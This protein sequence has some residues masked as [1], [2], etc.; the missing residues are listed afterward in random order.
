MASSAPSAACCSV[1][2]S[3][4]R[5]RRSPWVPTATRSFRFT[6]TYG[7]IALSAVIATF[8]ATFAALIPARKSSKLSVIEV[9][10]NA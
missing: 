2:S 6:S 10:R 3:R 1:C 8:A 4:S 7:F 5:S 9:I